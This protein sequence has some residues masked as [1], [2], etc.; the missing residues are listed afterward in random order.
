MWMKKVRF[1]ALVLSGCWLLHG[2][3][4]SQTDGFSLSQI[5]GQLQPPQRSGSLPP[6]VNTILHQPF[7]YLGKGAQ[8]YAF[9]SQDGQFVLKFLRQSR[10][11]HF[12]EPIR[13]LLPPPLKERLDQTI[14]KRRTKFQK[15]LAS[16][17]IGATLLAQE[18][19]TLYFQLAPSRSRESQVVLVDKLGIRHWVP[20]DHTSFAL[21]KKAEPIYSTLEKWVEQGEIEKAKQGLSHL[22]ALLK[23]RIELGIDDKN[24]DLATNFGFIDTDAIQFDMGRFSIRKEEG[25]VRD[26]LIRITDS[27]LDWLDAVAPDLAN[28]LQD[29]IEGI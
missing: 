11:S 3:C 16:Y 8:A 25:S 4:T 15:G 9:V 24:P 27:L 5:V 2:F 21:Q 19:G 6:N 1:I 7:F 22:V 14:A 17:T 20:L 13:F 29:E 10:G 12:L 23:T 28:H 18:T 26:E